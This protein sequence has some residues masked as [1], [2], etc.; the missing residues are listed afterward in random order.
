MPKK[1]QPTRRQPQ[2]IARRFP[3]GTNTIDDCYVLPVY[4]Y[5][6]AEDALAVADYVRTTDYT[7]CESPP[8]TSLSLK[9]QRIYRAA[10]RYYLAAL[11]IKKEEGK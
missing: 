10:A 6:T 4:E 7:P 9:E 5:Q 1:K 3:N 8:W 11:G 2:A